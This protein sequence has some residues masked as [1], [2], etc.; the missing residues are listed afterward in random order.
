MIG[1]WQSFFILS[2]IYWIVVAAVKTNYL[3]M[4]IGTIMF[5]VGAHFIT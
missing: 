2:G 5:V 3:A 1:T 4:I